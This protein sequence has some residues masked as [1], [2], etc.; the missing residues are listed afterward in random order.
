MINPGWVRGKTD[1]KTVVIAD[2]LK[3]IDHICQIAGS[4]KHC[5]IGSD[6]DGGYGK[7]QCPSDM[8]SIADLRKLIDLLQ[9]QGYSDDDI[10]GIMWRNWVEF[11]GRAWG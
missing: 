2:I 4:A 9:Q 3:H 8:D 5:G 6:L 7:E 10:E 11:F 1:P